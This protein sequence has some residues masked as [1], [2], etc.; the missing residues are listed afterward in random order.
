[1]KK[2]KHLAITLVLGIFA[3]TPLEAKASDRVIYRNEAEICSRY[4][5]ALTEKQN[6]DCLRV[7]EE[8]AYI[9]EL[10]ICSTFD[11]VLNS[12]QYTDCHRRI[13]SRHQNEVRR[14]E[15]LSHPRFR[16]EAKYNFIKESHR[17]RFNR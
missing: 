5:V 11:V 14:E 15:K 17:E 12:Q 16:G 7:L 2:F 9:R 6:A 3:N 1:M 4:N 10:N 13:N 8:L